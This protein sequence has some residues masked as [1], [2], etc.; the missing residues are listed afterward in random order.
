MDT[1]ANVNPMEE[2]NVNTVVMDDS[3]KDVGEFVGGLSPHNDT[4]PIASGLGTASDKEV[5]GIIDNSLFEVGLASFP[6][7]LSEGDI[8]DTPLS[9]FASPSSSNSN[10][11]V[12]FNDGFSSTGPPSQRRS[13][14]PSSPLSPLPASFS[15]ER[16]DEQSRARDVPSLSTLM[17]FDPT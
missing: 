1:Q 5:S 13:S 12:Q 15:D 11:E 16:L 17:F 8:Q 6:E 4:I 14:S 9:F 3:L 7:C 2:G 10:T